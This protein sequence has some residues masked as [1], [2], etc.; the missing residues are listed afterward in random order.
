MVKQKLSNKEE[1]YIAE[2]LKQFIKPKTLPDIIRKAILNNKWIPDKYQIYIPKGDIDDKDHFI[3]A[4]DAIKAFE[5][6][7]MSELDKIAMERILDVP[8]IANRI[9]YEY[10]GLVTKVKNS[11]IEGMENLPKDDDRV[12][13]HE[14]TEELNLFGETRKPMKGLNPQPI[15]H[16]GE[17]SKFGI[18]TK[19]EKDDNTGEESHT[20]NIAVR[21]NDDRKSEGNTGDTTEQRQS[22]IKNHKQY[23]IDFGEEDY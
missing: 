21:R 11:M 15:I 20:G 10:R 5:L 17:G 9:N 1:A 18:L 12:K 22:E 23:N 6:G 13:L 16:I 14:K 4:E 8:K 19:E 7:D 2:Q 3:V